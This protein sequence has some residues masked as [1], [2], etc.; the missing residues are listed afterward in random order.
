MAASI[1]TPHARCSRR[2]WLC[3]GTLSW[4]GI[5]LA[6]MLSAGAVAAPIRSRP[7]RGV[8]FAFCPGGPSH[9]E[10]LDPKPD[11]PKE[12]RGLFDTIATAL[13]GIRFG[14]HLPE[15]ARRL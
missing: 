9:L 6:D 5:G 12:V 14:E 13:P 4:L 8:I 11:A 10:T 2:E 1:F 3:A 7:I 15:L